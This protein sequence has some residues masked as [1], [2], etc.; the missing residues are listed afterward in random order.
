M[1][2]G[3]DEV[4]LNTLLSDVLNA[5]PAHSAKIYTPELVQ[6]AP[7]YF[8]RSLGACPSALH[9]YMKYYQS[10]D[11]W[12]KVALR[13]KPPPTGSII[14]TDSLVERDFLVRHEFY[15]DYLSSYDIDRCLVAIVD[16]G[17]STS[18]PRIRLC[19]MRSVSEPVFSAPEVQRLWQMASL[20]R[21]FVRLAS[22]HERVTRAAIVQQ[23]TIDMVRM[24]LFLIDPQRCVLLANLA[25]RTSLRSDGPLVVHHGMI[26]ARDRQ[27]DEALGAALLAVTNSP[28]EIRFVRLGPGR[29]TR[30]APALIVN[31]VTD[32]AGNVSA[33]ILRVLGTVPLPHDG[34]ALLTGLLGLTSAESA[35]ALLLAEG[36]SHE[37]IAIRRGV[38]VSTIRTVLQRVQEKLGIDRKGALARFILD[39][40]AAG[41]LHLGN[42]SVSRTN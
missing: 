3:N 20:A 14:N 6:S 21:S 30:N 33:I 5:V 39:I 25:A 9:D 19:I 8:G 40:S 37:D 13:F 15:N 1:F 31:T 18:L 12:A 41:G 24:P 23:S 42:G 7:N 11:L 4:G 17:R 38:K 28:K 36:L 32:E 34:E 29:P 27:G 22:A 35:A 26:R 16:D 2:D 10:V